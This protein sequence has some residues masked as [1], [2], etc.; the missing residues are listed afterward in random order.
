M[1]RDDVI[2]GRFIMATEPMKAYS[3]VQEFKPKAKHTRFVE[4]IYNDAMN[5]FADEGIEEVR[6]I[7]V[8]CVYQI[9]QPLAFLSK[10]TDE[11]DRA[12]GKLPQGIRDE[13]ARLTGFESPE[14]INYLKSRV[15]NW[16]KP[17]PKGTPERP[18]KT[19][20][21][22]LVERFL[23]HSINPSDTQIKMF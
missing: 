5:T 14:M 9:Y 13:M 21:M 23:P 17:Q 18:F 6:S 7:F 15:D 16:M 20:V 11:G 22:I 19:K 2:A 4:H 3:I 10:I 1:L 8:A 12:C